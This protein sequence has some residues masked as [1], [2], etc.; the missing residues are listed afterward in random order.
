MLLVSVASS[1]VH[2]VPCNLCLRSTSSMESNIGQPI[3]YIIMSTFG[4]QFSNWGLGLFTE[5]R[6]EYVGYEV[7]L[8]QVISDFDT[9]AMLR[10]MLCGF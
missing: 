7:K 3:L 9:F 2:N 6:M 10:V 5:I 1:A 4:H 8:R